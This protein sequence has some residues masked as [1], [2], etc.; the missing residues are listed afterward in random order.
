MSEQ[1]CELAKASALPLLAKYED[2]RAAGIV[3]SRASLHKLIHKRG[4]P[5]PKRQDGIGV[6]W[7]RNR[8]ML[9]LMGVGLDVAEPTPAVYAAVRK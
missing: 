8:V 4:F 1:T 2:L 3:G 9:W 7:E 5:P 6:R